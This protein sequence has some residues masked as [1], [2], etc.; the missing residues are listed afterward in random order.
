MARMGFMGSG[1]R[2]FVLLLLVLVLLAGG[3]IWFD[4]LGLVKVANLIG[5]IRTV[6]GL[7]K[8]PSVEELENPFLLEKERL[9]KQ[10]EQLDMIREE[11]E[12]RDLVL[13]TGEEEIVQIK[14]QLEERERALEE[15]EKS[16]N[17]R[18]NAFENRRVNL[19]QNAQYLVGMRP[20]QAVAM[21]MAMESDMDVID[22]LRMAEENA[23]AAGEQSLVAFWLSL[24]PPERSAT[25]VRKMG[26]PGIP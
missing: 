8:V 23:R 15:R 19:E 1:A 21:L 9:T 16:F 20:E 24:M 10:M 12:S 25:L 5:P 18:L 26:Q 4:F 2:I 7:A 3:L 14:E 11:L 22:I 17:E 6:F 13:A